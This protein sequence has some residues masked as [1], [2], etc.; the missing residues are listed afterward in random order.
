MAEDG[1]GMDSQCWVYPVAPLSY[2]CP[3]YGHFM[4][5]TWSLHGPS[6]WFFLNPKQCAKRYL[7]KNQLEGPCLDHVLDIKGPYFGHFYE[8]GTMGNNQNWE[9][10]HGASLGTLIMIQEKPI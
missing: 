10:G 9:I 3:K 4:A 8:M 2:K 1:G 7:M 5:Q 6:N